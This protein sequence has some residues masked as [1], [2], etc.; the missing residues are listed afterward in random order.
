MG[1]EI[2]LSNRMQKVDT[3]IFPQIVRYTYSL[4]RVISVAN[5]ENLGVFGDIHNP[6]GIIGIEM[7]CF[8]KG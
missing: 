4:S 5:A 1:R 8:C 7:L 6:Q 3:E 2:I